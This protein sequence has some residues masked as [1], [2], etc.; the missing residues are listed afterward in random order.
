MMGVQSF[1]KVVA[2]MDAVAACVP[3]VC[4]IYHDVILH[5]KGKLRGHLKHLL[6]ATSTVQLPLCP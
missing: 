6:V 3:D 2:M 1:C 4:L 5:S